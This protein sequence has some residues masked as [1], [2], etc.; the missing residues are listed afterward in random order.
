MTTLY[1]YEDGEMIKTVEVNMEDRES[2][3]KLLEET[4]NTDP[5]TLSQIELT[6]ER[7]EIYIAIS[8]TEYLW[9]VKQ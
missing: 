5:L 6:M 9:S 2:I 8:E 3:V 4:F 1:A 7:G